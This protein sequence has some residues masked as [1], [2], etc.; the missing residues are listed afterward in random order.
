MNESPEVAEAELVLNNE[1]GLHARPAAQLVKTAAC[2]VASI[3]MTRGDRTAD[4]H[5][6]FSLLALGATRG[7]TVMVRAEG[8]DARE[9][10]AAIAALI[11]NNFSE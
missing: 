7:S 8:P 9:A 3:T 6:L 4:A 5:S 1:V 11:E 10:V 2:F